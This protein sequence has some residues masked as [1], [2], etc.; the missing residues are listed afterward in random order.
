MPVDIHQTFIPPDWD[1]KWHVWSHIIKGEFDSVVANFPCQL[2]LDSD[3]HE[4]NDP[5]WKRIVQVPDL[6]G[7]HS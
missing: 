4:L 3:A 5:A 6:C 7:R 1:G 2:N